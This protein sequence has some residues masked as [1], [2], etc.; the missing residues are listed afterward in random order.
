[1]KLYTYF[2]SSAAYRIRIALN[3]KGV[4]YESIP[5]HL[6]RNGGEHLTEEYRTVN[7]IGLVPTLE[8]DEAFF[9]QSVAIAEYLEERY[10]Q[11]AILP[12]ALKDRAWVRAVAQVIACEI[13][14]LNNLRVLRYLSNE[15]GMQEEQRLAWYRHWVETGLA[16]V[17]KM[18]IAS[19]VPGRFCFGEEP[20][21]ADVFLVPQ[22]YNA[23]RFKCN[24][25]PFPTIRRV[26]DACNELDAFKRAAPEQQS[27][28]E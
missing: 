25:T 21:M 20:T 12:E 26:V 4:D 6:V 8:E 19:P 9:T 24:L 1:M 23:Q 3:L 10:A 28:A 17:E 7:P 11:P 5:V 18:L 15:A 22:I 27:D 14:P 2:R 13:H 16:A